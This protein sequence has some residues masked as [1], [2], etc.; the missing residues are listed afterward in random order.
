MR[1][2]PRSMPLPGSVDSVL[3][4]GVMPQMA[5]MFLGWPSAS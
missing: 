4:P 2:R 5:V 1:F 3:S